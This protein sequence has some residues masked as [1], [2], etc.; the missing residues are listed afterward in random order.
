MKYLSSVA[1]YPCWFT[2]DIVRKLN[3]KTIY[4][5]TSTYK[6]E[7]SK[8]YYQEFVRL[9]REVRKDIKVA[10]KK[11]LYIKFWKQYE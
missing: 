3:V 8:P 6:I 7:N 5:K 2:K 10:Y 11:D 1:Q 4:Y 9:R